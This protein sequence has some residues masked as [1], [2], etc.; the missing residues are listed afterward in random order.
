[1]DPQTLVAALD[2]NRSRLLGILTTI[3]KSGQDPQKVLAWRPAPGRAHIAWQAIHCAATHDKYLNVTVKGGK[4]T[5]EALVAN[6]GGGSTPSDTNVPDLAAIRSALESH[7]ANFR[8]YVAGISA[9]E[10]VRKLPNGRTVGESILL[11]TWHEAHHQ[12]QIHLTWNLFK[13]AHGVS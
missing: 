8:S 3:E 13:Q 10:L 9:D 1:M 2:F 4:P 11:L 5:D 7:Y 12:G 6:F